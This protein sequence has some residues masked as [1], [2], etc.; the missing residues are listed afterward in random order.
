[1]N[2]KKSFS[3]N[4]VTFMFGPPASTP[5]GSGLDLKVKNPDA[6]LSIL[7]YVWS[8]GRDSISVPPLSLSSYL[9]FFLFLFRAGFSQQEN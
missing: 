1:L 6:H 5:L 7:I 8:L 2:E 9:K 3:C 4:F